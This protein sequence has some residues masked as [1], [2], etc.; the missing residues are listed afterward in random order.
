M[1]FLQ[2]ANLL[3]T[4]AELAPLTEDQNLA[5]LESLFV[6]VL[7]DGR[8]DRREVKAFVASALSWPWNWGQSPDVLEAKLD[9]MAG[10]LRHV[11][12]A[13][14]ADH[15]VGLGPRIPTPALREKTFA[16]MFALMIADG[17][18]DEREK[19]AAQA[20]A[21]VFGIPTGRAIEIVQQVGSALMQAVGKR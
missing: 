4:A 7:A 14:L 8:V 12:R 1:K 20:F 9:A 17:R 15:L 3:P 2:Y 18:L 10:R 6:T 5:M 21:A 16:G 11:T 19:K 13:S